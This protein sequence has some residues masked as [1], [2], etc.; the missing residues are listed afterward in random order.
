MKHRRG[1]LL[2]AIDEEKET[3][4]EIHDCPH[5][6][7]KMEPELNSFSKMSPMRVEHVEKPIYELNPSF[8][9]DFST[10]YILD[11]LDEFGAPF[12]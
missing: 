1:S 6:K 9:Y 10:K 12:Y 2:E 3:L 8:D 4:E 5:T 11:G 7:K